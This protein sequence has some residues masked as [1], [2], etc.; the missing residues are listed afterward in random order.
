[1]RCTTF[2]MQLY[3]YSSFPLIGKE[4]AEYCAKRLKNLEIP[5][6]TIYY[7]T[8]A[9]ATETGLIISKHFEGW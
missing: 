9:R 5:I 8:M 6:D 4:Q 7:S 1:M 3:Y 2:S